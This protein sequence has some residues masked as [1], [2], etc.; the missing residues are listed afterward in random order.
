MEYQEQPP[1]KYSLSEI[2]NGI[3]TVLL[4]I[5]ILESCIDVFQNKITYNHYCCCNLDTIDQIE[6][7]SYNQ[8]N[9]VF[10]HNAFCLFYNQTKN[11]Y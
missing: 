9:S 11:F 4:C 6:N 8:K 7:K 10:S 5:L 3:C 2:M 1:K